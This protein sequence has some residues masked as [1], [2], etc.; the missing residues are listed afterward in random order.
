MGDSANSLN[1]SLCGSPDVR[2]LT[3]TTCAEI[4]D[5][6]RL[7][8]LHYDVQTE[9]RAVDSIQL[10]VCNVCDLRFFTPVVTGSSEFYAELGRRRGGRY[11]AEERSEFLLAA[12]Y[13]TAE[14]SV[15]DVGCGVGNFGRLVPGDYT[16]LELNGAAAATAISQG[17]NVL[18]ETLDVHVLMHSAAYSMVTAFQVLEHVESPRAFLL[19]TLAAVRVGGLVVLSVPCEESWASYIEGAVMNMPPHHVT[20]W[21]ERCL[22]SLVD[23]LPV[24]LVR[25]EQEA[26]WDA[27]FDSYVACLTRRIVRAFLRWPCDGLV[28]GSIKSRIV[29][30]IAQRLE[31]AIR[32]AVRPSGFQPKGQTITAVFERRA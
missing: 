21:S 20:R 22:R 28:D 13:L 31:N 12:Q 17:R 1:C 19:S 7:N 8:E 26:L 10:M 5:Q 23:H 15:L 14:M 4:A 3:T 9:F 16:G 27:H 18:A 32:E 30:R 25:I 2:M 24:R 11:Y 29:G 6:W